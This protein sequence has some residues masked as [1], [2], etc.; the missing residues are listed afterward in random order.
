MREKRGKFLI[1]AVRREPESVRQ[2][3]R[4]KATQR[5]KNRITQEGSKCVIKAVRE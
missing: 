5:G 3:D 4:N 1:R 2:Q